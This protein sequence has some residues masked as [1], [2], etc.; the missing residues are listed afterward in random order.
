MSRIFRVTVRGHFADLDA[1]TK[2]RLLADADAHAITKSAYTPEGFFTY[3]PS[4][5]AFSFRYEIRSRDDDAQADAEAQ[6]LSRAEA[7]LA[8]AGIGAKHVKV[9]SVDMADIWR[10]DS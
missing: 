9:K 6:G 4:L 1:E 2:E 8:E 7:F 10:D 3:E 5:V